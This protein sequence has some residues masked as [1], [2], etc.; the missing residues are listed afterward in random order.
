V[1][2]IAS[3]GKRVRFYSTI[4][5]VNLPEKEKRDGHAGRISATLMRMDLVILIA[6]AE[7]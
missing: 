4:D 7:S 2:G 3:K 6:G 1:S 5:L